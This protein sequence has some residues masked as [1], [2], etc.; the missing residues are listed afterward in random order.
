M[1][2]DMILII[3]AGAVGTTLAAFLSRAGQPVTMLVREP[4]KYAGQ[5]DIVIESA[6][7]TEVLRAPAPRVTGVLDL[8]GI[9]YVFICVKHA[10][11]GDVLMQFP[12]I[13]PAGLTLVSTLNGVSAIPQMTQRYP[14]ERLA[15]MTVMF[16]AQGLAPLRARLQSHP[17]VIV[18]ST[19]TRLLKLFNGSGMQVDATLG[20]GIAWGKLLL[21]LANSICAVTH[22][23]VKDLLS[24][25]DLQRVYVAALD[26][27]VAVLKHAGIAY[28]FPIPMPYPAY[29]LLMR[30]GGAL[31][32]WLARRQNGLGDDSY[33]SMVADVE[34]GR[35]TEIEEINGELV[36]VGRRT[37]FST[38]INEA[39][40]GLIRSFAGKVPPPYLS[41]GQLRARL[42]L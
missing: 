20:P 17:R 24:Q 8:A 23:P 7:G 25:A 36:A 38:P 4:R 22:A 14:A 37:N 29:R 28:R 27:A 40:V 6:S 35:D 32:W 30:Y 2:G 21:N 26:E 19:D 39:L 31:P 3:G 13:L 1:G 9:N 41:P 15:N 12:A 11:L 18:D 16:T 34:A 33:P 42:G 5:T 10:A